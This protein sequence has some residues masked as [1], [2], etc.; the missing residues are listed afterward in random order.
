MRPYFSS[1]FALVI[2]A[3]C[4]DTGREPTGIE[5]AMDPSEITDQAPVTMTGEQRGDL[6]FDSGLFASTVDQLLY[7]LPVTRGD[8][9][10]ELSI[11]LEGQ[12]GE[13]VDL[14]TIR[15]C[16]SGYSEENTAVDI[17]DDVMDQTQA[18]W[19]TLLDDEATAKA[20]TSAS[21]TFN[22]CVASDRTGCYQSCEAYAAAASTIVALPHLNTASEND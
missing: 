17:P 11:V 7:V 22:G 3:A 1:V 2:L 16:L 14:Q 18:Q 12:T 20:V 10:D 9:I 15:T 21:T 6:P 4:S 13:M 8:I 5:T 19:S